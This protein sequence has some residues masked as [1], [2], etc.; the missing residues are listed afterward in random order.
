M[1]GVSVERK[2]SRRFGSSICCGSRKHEQEAYSPTN[3]GDADRTAGDGR[4]DE[5]TGRETEP[6][7]GATNSTRDAMRERFGETRRETAREG[8]KTV[9]TAPEISLVAI[10]RGEA[11]RF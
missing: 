11:Y 10:E 5:T 2:E 8:D 9:K 1:S 6:P 7:N 3:S 4:I